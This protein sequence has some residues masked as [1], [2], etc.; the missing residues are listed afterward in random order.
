MNLSCRLTKLEQASIPIIN[1]YQDL[2]RED[3]DLLR[4][5][6]LW[7]RI[8]KIYRNHIKSKNM[9]ITDEL[10]ELIIKKLAEALVEVRNLSDVEVIRETE[11][12][13]ADHPTGT[14]ISQVQSSRELVGKRDKSE[15]IRKLAV[16]WNPLMIELVEDAFNL[17]EEMNKGR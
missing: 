14:L 4:E 10:A 17:R 7:H 9:E 5:N 15:S 3:F 2:T 8:V 13:W 1:E 11:E 6:L 12:F 16:C